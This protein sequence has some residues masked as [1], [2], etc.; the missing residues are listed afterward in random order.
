MDNVGIVLIPMFLESLLII[1]LDHTS[2]IFSCLVLDETMTLM[3][4]GEYYYSHMI[5]I[6]DS[7]KIFVTQFDYET[8]PYL[9]F[10]V[11]S[12]EQLYIEK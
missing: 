10:Y 2:S 4:L 1:V 11:I 6:K 5:L 9:Y 12:T 3:C 7:N 8:K